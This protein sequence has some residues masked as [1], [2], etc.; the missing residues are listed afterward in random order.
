M[1][2]FTVVFHSGKTAMQMGK[3]QGISLPRPNL[4]VVR[5]RSKTYPKRSTQPT[6]E[7]PSVHLTSTC[8]HFFRCFIVSIV[9]AQSHGRSRLNGTKNDIKVLGF[10]RKYGD[11]FYKVMFGYQARKGVS[12]VRKFIYQGKGFRTETFL[13]KLASW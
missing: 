9:T 4:E 12:S 6:S 7:H 1:I 13:S 2:I 10:N 5:T 11:A 8:Y 3:D